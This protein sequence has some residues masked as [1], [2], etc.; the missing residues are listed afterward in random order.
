MN[1]LIST[2]IFGRVKRRAE[3]VNY[4]DPGLREADPHG[5]LLPHEDV[6]VVSLAKTTLQLIQLTRAEP[7]NQVIFQRMHCKPV[8]A[9]SES[10]TKL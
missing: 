10:E 8:L 4:L 9:S 6:R 5:E 3:T 7:A 2:E 1:A